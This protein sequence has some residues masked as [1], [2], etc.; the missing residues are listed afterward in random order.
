MGKAYRVEDRGDDRCEPDDPTHH[1]GGFDGEHLLREG[2]RASRFGKHRRH[3]SEAECC[4]HCDDA[5]QSESQHCCR[6]SRGKG[7]TGQ[8]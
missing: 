5:I 2:V 4:Q 6:P 3:F 7:R 1:K 8:C